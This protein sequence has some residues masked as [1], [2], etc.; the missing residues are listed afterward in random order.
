MYVSLGTHNLFQC[1]IAGLFPCSLLTVCSLRTLPNVRELRIDEINDVIGA[2]LMAAEAIPAVFGL[3][4]A[5][6]GDTI[7]GIC[8][9]VNI[10]NDTDTVATM[11]GGILGALNGIDSMPEHYLEYLEE[12]NNIKLAKLAE[13]ICAL[14]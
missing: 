5:A 12:Q 7:E 8:A 1:C 10:G 3:M 9:G 6:R 11:I 13:D 4:V 14:A 2:G